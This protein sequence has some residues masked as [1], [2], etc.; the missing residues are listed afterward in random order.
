MERVKHCGASERADE[1][2]GAN[3]RAN[4]GP[5]FHGVVFG[6]VGTTVHRVVYALD[7][8]KDVCLGRDD[9][10]WTAVKE[11]KDE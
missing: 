11:G 2:C 6:H 5:I 9:E 7:L 1:H 8:W 4:E 3:E 10:R